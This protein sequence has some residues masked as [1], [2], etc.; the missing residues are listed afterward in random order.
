M[1]K[2][3]SLSLTAEQ[4]PVGPVGPVEEML[5]PASK[6]SRYTATSFNKEFRQQRKRYNHIVTNWVAKHTAFAPMV[7]TPEMQIHE[8]S[9]IGEN[10]K[11]HVIVYKDRRFIYKTFHLEAEEGAQRK[12]MDLVMN[13]VRFHLRAY[14]VVLQYPTEIKDQH[15]QLH[16]VKIPK[17][18]SVW[19]GPLVAQL[20][21]E[22]IDFHPSLTP[23]KKMY[24]QLERF[25]SPYFYH[26]DFNSGNLK[27][28][29]EENLVL[30]DF[31]SGNFFKSDR[32]GGTRR[33]RR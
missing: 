31:G 32:K 25:Y 19:F 26:N 15:Q 22:Y 23:T 8:N 7:F 3:P 11:L 20:K 12:L 4:R 14:N 17:L 21:M 29:R 1:F 10:F 5:E 28:D 2:R 30:L 9:K 18:E 6:K 13:E 16:R 33:L 24:D 27:Y